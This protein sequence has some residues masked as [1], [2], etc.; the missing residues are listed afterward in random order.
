MIA[1]EVAR[2]KAEAL[3]VQAP[4]KPTPLTGSGKKS[5]LDV[6]S[7][8]KPELAGAAAAAAQLGVFFGVVADAIAGSLGL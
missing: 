2:M 4:D 7:P 3:A 8:K 1:A 6:A 5:A